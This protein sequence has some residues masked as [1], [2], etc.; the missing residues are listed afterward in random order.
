[1]CFLH[2]DP[3]NNI[4]YDVEDILTHGDMTTEVTFLSN[5]PI[6]AVQMQTMHETFLDRIRMAGKNDDNWKERKRELRRMKEQ[7]EQ[8]PKNWQLEDGLIYYKN[9]L[10]VP[11]NEDLLTDIANGC[12]DS[13]VA[14][15]FGQEKTI[16]LVTWIF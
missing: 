9:R 5:V 16:E 11:S 3:W 15:H 8:V 6:A 1:M 13:K 4:Y 12:H 7:N 10:F 2:S 14:G